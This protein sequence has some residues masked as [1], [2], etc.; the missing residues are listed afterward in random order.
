MRYLNTTGVKKLKTKPIRTKVNTPLQTY[1][2]AKWGGEG[3]RSSHGYITYFLNCPI[4]WTLKRQ[5]CVASSTCHAEYM[6]LGT[7]C[8]DAVWLQN[9]IEDLTGD[10]N[11]VSMHCDNT[12]AIH[13]AKDNLS[14]K[15]TRHTDREFY[16]VNEQIYK[17]RIF[18][19]LI[20]SK[21]QQADI[22]TKPLGPT[23][24]NQALHQLR[25]TPNEN[26]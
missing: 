10:G 25:L 3:A 26:D 9:L 22:L 14:N 15:H 24:H 23:L 4:S 21:S 13:V 2:D 17:G 1:V 16:Y 8:R 5:T 11:I 7:A 18:L 6:A 20:D 19:N 12:S